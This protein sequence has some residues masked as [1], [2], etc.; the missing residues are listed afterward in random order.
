MK[1]I[2]LVTLL[3][4]ATVCCSDPSK[5][6]HASRDYACRHVGNNASRDYCAITYFQLLASP[7]SYE[8]ERILLQAWAVNVNGTTILFPTKESLDGAETVSSVVAISGSKLEQINELLHRD[9]EEVPRRLTIGGIF[10][11]NI[12]EHR[13]GGF[14]VDRFGSLS[15]VDRFSL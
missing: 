8:G 6:T 7:S 10:K 4:L 9:G 12:G 3:A 5:G 14:D 15:E 13:L 11:Q 1:N 2:C